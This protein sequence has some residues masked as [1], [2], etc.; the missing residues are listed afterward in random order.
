MPGLLGPGLL[1]T[2]SSS[3]ALKGA[4]QA[5]VR[6]YQASPLLLLAF[7]HLLHP[8]LLQAGVAATA[9]CMLAAVLG[10]DTAFPMPI[11]PVLRWLTPAV[12]GPLQ[13]AVAAYLEYRMRWKFAQ[14]AWEHRAA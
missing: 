5:N 12:G 2:Y 3:T 4:M 13:I 1:C 7:R 8:V 10:H 6:G 9:V 14:T 11:S